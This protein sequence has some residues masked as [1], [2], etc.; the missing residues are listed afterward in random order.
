[1]PTMA[2]MTGIQASGKSTFYEGSSSLFEVAAIALAGI[3][4]LPSRS[5]FRA[6]HSCKRDCIK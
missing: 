2:I 5:S 4:A 3:F 1:M 6:V